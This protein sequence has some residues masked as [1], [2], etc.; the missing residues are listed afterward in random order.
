M[1]SLSPGYVQQSTAVYTGRDGAGRET[2]YGGRAWSV[3]KPQSGVAVLHQR[4]RRAL[5]H[6]GT[7]RHPQEPHCAGCRPTA[8]VPD[9]LVS[10]HLY[11]YHLICLERYNIQAHPAILRN[12][13]VQAADPPPPPPL[14]TRYSR[15]NPS[16]SLPSDWLAETS[17]ASCLP[18]DWRVDTVYREMFA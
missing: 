1:T 3:G 15:P 4:R 2:E 14:G 18:S 5:Q 17:Y 9:I 7:P 12:L 11:P 16:P 10:A 8:G 13:T 6:T